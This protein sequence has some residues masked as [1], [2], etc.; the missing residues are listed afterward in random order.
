MASIM[1][2]KFLQYTTL[3]TISVMS[4]FLQNFNSVFLSGLES[5]MLLD[6]FFT[7]EKVLLAHP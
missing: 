7:I 2:S 5:L 4:F 3:V 1:I 6:F